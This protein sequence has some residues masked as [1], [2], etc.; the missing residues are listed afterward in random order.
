MED[1]LQSIR[2]FTHYYSSF[3]GLKNIPLGL[4]ILVLG[5]QR[6]G[7]PFLGQ[8]GDCTVTLPLLL[9]TLISYLVIERYYHRRFGKVTLRPSP[10]ERFLDILFSIIIPA[11]A[12]VLEWILFRL[13]VFLQVSLVALSMGILIAGMGW[14]TRR[15]YYQAFG[16]L[17]GLTGILPLIKNTSAWSPTYGTFGLIFDAVFAFGILSTSLL[18]HRRLLGMLHVEEGAAGE[19][20]ER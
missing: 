5:L 6:L 3:Q 2:I 17:M 19:L 1:S 7:L 15:W 8:Q 20:A 11:L 4:F 9:L 13:H 10:R 14:L 18:D 12:L 16:I